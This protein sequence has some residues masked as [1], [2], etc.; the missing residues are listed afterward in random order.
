MQYVRFILKK[1]PFQAQELH[2]YGVV[3]SKKREHWSKFLMSDP[4][5]SRICD[6]KG[7]IE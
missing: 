6:V 2:D 1:T 4:F 5:N 3:W 7:I